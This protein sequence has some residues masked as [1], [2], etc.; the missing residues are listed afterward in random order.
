MLENTNFYVAT[1]YINKKVMLNKYENQILS[2][3]RT[4]KFRKVKR[5][6][7]GHQYE[8]ITVVLKH[9]ISQNDP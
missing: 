6:C 4:P 8:N 9:G 5:Q 1:K 7:L 2:R 3:Y